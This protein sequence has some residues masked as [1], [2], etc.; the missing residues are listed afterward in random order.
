VLLQNF[1]VA[2]NDHVVD[3]VVLSSSWMN[4]NNKQ[5][6]MHCKTLQGPEGIDNN[7]IHSRPL[8]NFA[9]A[10]ESRRSDT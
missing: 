3:V 5:I 2:L 10:A 8:Q 4:N 7:N 9:V 1:A 6:T